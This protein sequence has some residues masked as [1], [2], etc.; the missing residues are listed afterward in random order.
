MNSAE[1]VARLA[2]I[3]IYPV[4]SLGGIEVESA[5][6]EGPGL[7]DD[8]R[9]MVV[10]PDGLFLTRRE[11]PAMFGVSVKPEGEGFRLAAGGR[12][13]A[14]IPR[15]AAPGESAPVR[16]WKDEVVAVSGPSEADAWVSEALGRRCR[17]VHLPSVSRRAVD[18]RYGQPGDTVSFADGYPLLLASASS[19]AD[20]ER[21]VGRTLSMD[22]FR[23]NLVVDGSPAFAED[24]WRR[25]SVGAVRFDGVKPCKRCVVVDTDPVDGRRSDGVLRALAAFRRWGGGVRFGVNLVPRG[26]GEVRVGDDVVI[27]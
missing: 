18:P 13:S 4:K 6:V 26:P 24:D 9:W 22:R 7:R 25:L 14:W 1:P 20:V 2:S 15:V 19:L 17:L 8:R 27:R 16:V 10:D 5:V 21:R 23:P 11:V 3:R 12:G